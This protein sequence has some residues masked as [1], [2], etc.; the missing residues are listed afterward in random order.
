MTTTD[1]IVRTGGSARYELTSAILLYT[2]RT[3]MD[4]TDVYATVHDIERN[5]PGGP[6]LAAGKPAT[7]E[8]CAAFARAMADR[9]AFSGWIAPEILFIGPRTV[10][11]W[12]A[13]AVAT[14]FF[15]TIDDKDPARHI[16]E[17]NGRIQQPGLVHVLAEGDWSVFAVKGAARPGPA[18]PLFHAPY[19]NVYANGG[20]CE[21]NIRR[22]KRVTPETLA[23]FERAFFHSRF[24]HPN[25]D[26]RKL[27]RYRGGLHALWRDLLDGKHKTFPEGS[28]LPQGKD[29]LESLLRRLEKGEGKQ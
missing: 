21:G 18:T 20:L 10:A 5:R 28:L 8:S 13:P 23:E 11:W 7:T 27:T 4:G 12:R 26:S 2:S 25:E 24:T 17:R 29:T 6:R 14:M 1:V 22:P 3:A 9:A 15:A 16:G 19:F